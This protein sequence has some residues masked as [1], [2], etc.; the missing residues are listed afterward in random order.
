MRAREFFKGG[1]ALTTLASIG[2]LW[3]QH[4]PQKLEIDELSS[5]KDII[6]YARQVDRDVGRIT[7]RV[8]SVLNAVQNDRISADRLYSP[9]VLGAITHYGKENPKLKI[10]AEII[11]NKCETVLIQ[12]SQHRGRLNKYR[13]ILEPP[14]LSHQGDF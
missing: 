2:V 11:I 7:Q 1:L 8:L 12:K 9:G 14:Q 4:K 13:T 5:D 3:W 10:V 6:E